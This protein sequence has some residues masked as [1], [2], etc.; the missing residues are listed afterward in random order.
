M[1]SCNCISSFSKKVC[2]KLETT[3]R[4]N[5]PGADLL[6]ST[7]ECGKNFDVKILGGNV[8]QIDEYPWLALIEYTKRKYIMGFLTQNA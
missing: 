2:C 3:S 6:P 4:F 7:R 5:N 1:Y 8:T